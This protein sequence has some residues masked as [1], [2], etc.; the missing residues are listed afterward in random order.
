[1]PGASPHRVRS[2]S[3]RLSYAFIGVVALLLLGFAVVAGFVSSA[4][5]SADLERRADHASQL[6]AISLPIA[7]WK[8][9]ILVLDDIVKAMMSDEAI[10]YV[11]VLDQ[12]IVVLR[13]ARK[14][15]ED[16]DYAYFINSP[17]FI[18]EE[19]QLYYSGIGHR[20]KLVGAIKFVVS[21]EGV[22]KEVISNI[23]SIIALTISVIV[24]I[25]LTSIFITRRYISRP[26]SNLQ[27]SAAL[28]AAG[29]LQA[30]IDKSSRDEI[31]SLAQDLD[32]M[33]GS[34]KGAR[35]NLEHKVEARTRDLTAALEQQT[36]ASEVLGMISSSPTDVQPV[37]D[38]ISES[39]SRVCSAPDAQIFQINGDQLR[40]VAKHGPI[41]MWSIGDE[42]PV[43][44]NWV[45]G[46]AVVDRQTIH[47]DD[48]STAEI[49]FP[50]GAA[51]AKQYGHRTTIATPLLR[52]GIPIGAILMRR[53]E[54]RPFTPKQIE[55]LKTC[56]THRISRFQSGGR[57][58]NGLNGK[59]ILHRFPTVTSEKRHPE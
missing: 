55:L 16:K 47:V 50:E 2:I 51:Y 34:I 36:A 4:R 30:P 42:R 40:L 32:A 11:I 14:Q 18:V 1:M 59:S 46:R 27:N 19:R 57:V 28:I 23:L 33:R 35:E 56:E 12:Q 41:K 26:L 39:A 44:R 21:R 6:A 9:D 24:A 53:T 58:E 10:V 25:S 13:D 48:L 49:E 54:V 45:T 5:I 37:F 17:Q 15:Y 8:G 3:H 22:R 7:L 31:G 43:N 38:M 29:D 20:N 52:E